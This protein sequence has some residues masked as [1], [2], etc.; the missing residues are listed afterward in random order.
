MAPELLQNSSAKAAFATDVYSVTM[1]FLVFNFHIPICLD[2][3]DQ[4]RVL[5]NLHGE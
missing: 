4:F 5:G 1:T 2:L 3:F